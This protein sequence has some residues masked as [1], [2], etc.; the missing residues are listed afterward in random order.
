MCWLCVCDGGADCSGFVVCGCW[1]YC[2][3]WL[4]A[5]DGGANCGGFVVCG[6][7]GAL[8]WLVVCVMI[9]VVLVVRW[10]S[11]DGEDAPSLQTALAANMD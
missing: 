2:A 5:C 3:W 7:E 4:C 8:R 10:Q 9:A 11:H 6:R 1:G